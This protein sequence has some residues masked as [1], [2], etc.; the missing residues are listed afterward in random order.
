MQGF[1]EIEK[2]KYVAAHDVRLWSSG[3]KAA[4][5]TATHFLVHVQR[6]EKKGRKLFHTALAGLKYG[7]TQASVENENKILEKRKKRIACTISILLGALLVVHA[8]LYKLS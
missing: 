7:H 8:G 4:S 5:V 3:R 6:S 2:N 1:T